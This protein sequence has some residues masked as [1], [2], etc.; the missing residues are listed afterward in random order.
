MDYIDLH[1]H[2]TFSF[3]DACGLPSQL[4]DRASELGRKGLAIT[5]HG[6]VSSFIKLEKSCEE[7]NMKPIYGC[8]FYTVSDINERAR[9]RTHITCL[10]KNNCGYENLMKLVTESWKYG[11]Y[12]K[13]R[14]DGKLLYKHHENLIILS[15]CYS[16]S[17]CRK[18]RDEDYK[19]AYEI[20]AE[21]KAIFG[22]DYYLEIH[23]LE[24]TYEYNKFLNQVSLDLDIPLVMANDVHFVQKGYHHVQH[25]LH[26]IRGTSE[27]KSSVIE[28]LYLLSDEEIEQIIA[29]FPGVEWL[30]AIGNTMEIFEKI[31]VKI[32]TMKTIEYPENFT[33]EDSI[34][35]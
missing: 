23:P 5:D 16:S 33:F 15:G 26:L 24:L 12:Y 1:V 31:N 21:F 29:K 14:I 3:L 27:D 19:R 22:S 2:S 28:T 9:D 32:P 17:L 25:L 4:V 13:P 11:F 18:Y 6:I 30:T 34:K 7:K 20:A 8:E 35:N 10:A